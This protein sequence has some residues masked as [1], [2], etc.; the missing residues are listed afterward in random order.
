MKLRDLAEALD[1]TSTI[2]VDPSRLFD[3]FYV[4]MKFYADPD[5]SGEM[6]AYYPYWS[7]N[8]I[9]MYPETG[10]DFFE[11]SLVHFKSMVNQMTVLYRGSPASS[12]MSSFIKNWIINNVHSLDDPMVVRLPQHDYQQLVTQ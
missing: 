9:R 3:G 12:S 11:V 6:S 7:N 8:N 10:S 4:T 1:R 2:T 5:N